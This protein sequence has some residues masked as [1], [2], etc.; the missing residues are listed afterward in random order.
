MTLAAH[1][2]A[3]VACALFAAVPARAGVF[4]VAEPWTRPAA[5]G[6]STEAFMQIMSS[7]GATLVEVRSTLAGR[8]RLVSG[9]TRQDPPF[10][11]AL[12][13]RATVKLAPG[14]TRVVLERLAR[15]LKLR[16]RVPLTLVLRNADGTMQEIAVDA[17]V[18]RRSPSDDHRVP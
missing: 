14:G 8:V 2:A 16:D 7:G 18:R 4:S 17:E 13:P 11:L 15:P 1:A 9:A 3:L 10:A 5:A 12:P 6:A